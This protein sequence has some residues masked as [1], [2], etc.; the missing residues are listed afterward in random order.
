MLQRY[1]LDGDDAGRY[2]HACVPEGDRLPLVLAFHGGG[3]TPLD[4]ARFCR[5]AETAE[6][7]RFAVVFP[8]GSGPSSEYLTWNAGIC[9][10]HAARRDVDDVGFAGRLLDHLVERFAFDPAR[11]YATGM[12]NGAMFCY[13]LAAALPHRIAAIAPV[14]GCVASE[15]PS[16]PAVVPVLHLH[17]TDDHF[18]PYHGGGGSRSLRQIDFPSVRESLSRWATACG[19]PPTEPHYQDIPHDPQLANDQ[20]LFA[21]RAVYA[22]KNGVNVVVEIRITGGGHTWPGQAPLWCFLGPTM[23]ALPASDLVWQFF[24]QFFCTQS[25]RE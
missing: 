1:E 5:L 24:A 6:R 3:S 10:G 4:M 14:A 12:S 16:L 25:S 13:R 21:Q 18:V 22:T 17:G 23:L 19:L 11:V 7:H 2:Y 20:G 15:V 8:S 9:C